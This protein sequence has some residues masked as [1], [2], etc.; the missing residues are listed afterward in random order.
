MVRPIMAASCNEAT[1][2]MLGVKRNL[3]S[4]IDRAETSHKVVVIEA[5]VSFETMDN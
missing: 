2:T 1:P 4:E 3:L 5:R